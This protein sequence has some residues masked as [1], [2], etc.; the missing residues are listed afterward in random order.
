MRTLDQNNIVVPTETT[1]ANYYRKE[2][3]TSGICL[4]ASLQWAVELL[5]KASFD[6]DVNDNRLF[7]RTLH[8]IR[9]MLVTHRKN[10]Y[11]SSWALQCYYESIDYSDAIMDERIKSLVDILN[12]Q[13]EQHSS[14]IK[15]D[16]T[17]KSLLL[18]FYFYGLYGSNKKN[19]LAYTLLSGDEVRKEVDEMLKSNPCYQNVAFLIVTR[20]EEKIEED[21]RCRHCTA[22]I[23][24]ENNL[25]FYDVNKGVYSI[26]KVA[27]YPYT[28]ES[29][30]KT[31][32]RNWGIE[33]LYNMA[34]TPQHI[35][36]AIDTSKP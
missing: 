25:Y 29:L 22:I 1:F 4:G 2:K 8:Q 15:K 12:K 24:N 21:R 27:E 20:I 34:R 14:K 5:N 17:E 35:R 26:P 10:F 31:V 9:R 33:V 7:D 13:E 30:I 36:I 28:C 23:N 32:R 16:N 11:D 18:D 6:L 19:K 3:L